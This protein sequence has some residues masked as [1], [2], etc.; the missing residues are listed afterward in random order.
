MNILLAGE[1]GRLDAMA[2]P[3]AADVIPILD[4]STGQLKKT[5]YDAITGGQYVDVTLSSA[6]VLAL[7]ATPISV[8]AAPGAGFVNVVSRVLATKAAGTAYA[9]IAAGEDIA[10]RYTDASGSIAATIEATGFLD[11]TAATIAVG[12]AALSPLPV[13][14]AA[15]VAHMTTGEVT[16]GNSPVKLRIFYQTVP[17]AL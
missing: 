16:T 6:Q 13:A 17:A 5:T 8:L 10:I 9:G 14:N 1:V 12:N 2:L 11:S 3:A 7:N 15:L 4:V